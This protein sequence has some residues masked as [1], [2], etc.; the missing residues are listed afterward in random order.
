MCLADDTQ[1][2]QDTSAVTQDTDV[3]RQRSTS[4]ADAAMVPAEDII[5]GNWVHSFLWN[6]KM[7]IYHNS[8]CVELEDHLSVNGQN[9]AISK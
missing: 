7:I 9:N 4:A 2:A 5:T 8:T 1:K 3:A 6:M